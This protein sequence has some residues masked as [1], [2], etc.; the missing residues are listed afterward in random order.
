MKERICQI[1]SREELVA[2]A[3][4]ELS[5]AEAE[6]IA[7]HIATCLD[8]QAV[9]EALKRSLEITQAI[10]RASEAQWAKTIPLKQLQP[11]KR[12][13]RRIA[14]VAAGI[15]ILLGAGAVWQML[16][17]PTERARIR[18]EEALAGEIKRKIA[19]SGDAARL[20]A[21]A[22]LL[23]RYP[24][25]KSLVKERYQYIVE[26]YPE[27]AAAAEARPKLQQFK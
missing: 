21:A 2:Y 8:C 9:T 7:E 13:F 14:T 27:T 24:E 5:R 3:D 6:R 18:R 11:N 16:S 22:E 25:T 19:D 26:T 23:S 4:G 17:G 1:V 15:L 10:W 12:S 20:L